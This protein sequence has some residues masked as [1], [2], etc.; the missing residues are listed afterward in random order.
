LYD[1]LSASLGE[2]PGPS[3]LL[4]PKDVQRANVNSHTSA[5]DLLPSLERRAPADERVR[6]AAALLSRARRVLVIAG[7]GVARHDA[8]PE[9]ATFVAQMDACV[10]VAPDAR[11][12]FDNFDPRFMGLVGVMGN[13]SLA[14]YLV[15]ADACVVVGTR[16]PYHVRGGLEAELARRPLVSVHFEPS[17][18]D[19]A[20]RVELLGDVKVGLR[21]LSAHI[22]ARETQTIALPP[23]QELVTTFLPGVRPQ[24]LEF[25]EALHAVMS[26]VPE[27]ANIV[28]DAGNTGA[29][30]AHWIR[31]PRHGRF[32]LALGMGGMGYSFGAGIGAAFANGRRTFVLAGDGAFFMHGLEVH[33]ALQYRLPITFIVFNNNAHGM[34]FTREHLYFGG[35][36]SFNLFQPSELADGLGAMFP[37][38]KVLPGRTAIE[39]GESLRELPPGPAVMSIQVDPGEVSPFL[40]FLQ[41]KRLAAK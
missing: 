2:R 9:L 40:P 26:A 24:G 35:K 25:R 8:R 30:A 27:D 17:F 4:L 41:V 10:A 3:V 20:P 14:E 5:F 12:V 6:E 23:P 21:A 16:L 18:E 28:V 13:P 31:S 38:L 15:R 29:S 22:G 1:A 19:G 32:L 39:I 36:Y 37:S 11:D 33:T 7:D 34:C